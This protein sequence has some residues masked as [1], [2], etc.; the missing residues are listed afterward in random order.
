MGFF[1][2]EGV[3]KD[4]AASHFLIPLTVFVEVQKTWGRVQKRSF[5]LKL[6]L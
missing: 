3:C 5:W 4:V 1:V 6:D 2:H